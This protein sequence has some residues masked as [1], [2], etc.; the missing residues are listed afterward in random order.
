MYHL[1]M[2]SMMQSRTLQSRMRLYKIHLFKKGTVRLTHRVSSRDLTATILVSQ[3][4]EMAAMLVPQ[5]NPMGFKLYS[6][7]N[8]SY[9][10]RVVT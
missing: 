6:Y 10:F 7:S 2:T 3:N 9:C 5:T 8:I 4:N 1:Q